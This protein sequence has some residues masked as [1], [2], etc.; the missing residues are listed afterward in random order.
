M[1]I[2]LIFLGY[3][4]IKYKAFDLKM[5]TVQALVI[6]LVV[7]V[8]SQF[9]FIR[10]FSGIILN[11]ITLILVFFVG[12]ALIR[13]V[14]KEIES[15]NQIEKLANELEISN[16]GQETFIHFLSH[17]IKGYLSVSR[18]AF[19]SIVEGDY[20]KDV[21]LELTK[22]AQEGLRRTVD[23]VDVVE[24]ILKSSNLKSGKV[25]YLMQPFDM[26]Q[27]VMMITRG[28]SPKIKE[29]GLTLEL[30]A[31]EHEDYTVVGDKENLTRHVIKNLVDNAINYT[32]KGKIE[33]NLEK[34][35]KTLLFSIKDSGVGIIPEDKPKLF[36]EGGR[37]T[38]S[39]KTNAHSTGYGLFIAK[40]IVVAHKGNIWVES[41]GKDKGSTFFV[42]LPLK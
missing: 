24:N 33:I 18:N 22:M 26:Y 34:K 7:L 1:P 31:N 38:D 19:S 5:F 39:I 30:N 27:S 40:N 20:G 16:K 4:V 36:K 42:E 28:V 17:E 10:D 11:S 35:E 15:K 12:S 6:V 41:E 37:G 8:G 13:N 3:L 25:V 29:K 2:L 9:A 23:G 21:P 14:K 32:L